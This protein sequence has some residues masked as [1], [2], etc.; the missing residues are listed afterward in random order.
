MF[1]AHIPIGLALGR[2][3]TKRSLTFPVI[4][5]AIFGAI[6]PDLDLIR[7]YLFDNHQRHHHD[8]W[9]HIP[10]VWV[11]MMLG[12]LCLTKF[13][14]RPFGR[15]ALV[16][17]TA[18]L[19]H[20]LLDTMAGAIEWLWPFSDRGFHIVTVPA[21]HA[22]W[23]LSFLTHWTFALEILISLSALCVAFIRHGHQNPKNPREIT[24]QT[25]VAIGL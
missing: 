11:L 21:T 25:L 18:I 9:T 13:L 22:K 3:I 7:F 19:S 15:L 5:V 1:I 14:K 23:Y 8:Y 17:F 10:G 2:L 24:S 12:W 20:L 16:F 6:F 4:A